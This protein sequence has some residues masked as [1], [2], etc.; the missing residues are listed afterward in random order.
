M[1]AFGPDDAADAHRF[2]QLLRQQLPRAARLAVRL[3]GDVHAAEEVL[4]EAM[5]RAVRG[6][7]SFRGEAEI[8]TW[9]YAIVLNT[10]RDSL[11]RQQSQ[12][13]VMRLASAEEPVDARRSSLEQMV[14]RE[15]GARVAAHVSALPPRQRE[16]LVLTFY[17]QLSAEQAAQV[18]QTSPENVRVL[19]HHARQRLKRDLADLL[20]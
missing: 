17:E 5:L 4:G 3:C 1:T 18:M 11:R 15:T 16:A 2:A 13:P 20:S 19:V 8:G 7:A 12:Q 6:R 9:L 10:F 14:G